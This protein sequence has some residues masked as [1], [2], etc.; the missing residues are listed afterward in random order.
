[1]EKQ[2]RWTVALGRFASRLYKQGCGKRTGP[3]LAVADHRPN[4]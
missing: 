2:A 1:M 4:V 3:R